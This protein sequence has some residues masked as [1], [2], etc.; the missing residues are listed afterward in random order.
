MSEIMLSDENKLNK[1]NPY[2][3]GLVAWT[4][5]YNYEQGKTVYEEPQLDSIQ[6]MKGFQEMNGLQLSDFHMVRTMSSLEPSREIQPDF[7][8][9]YIDGLLGNVFKPKDSPNDNIPIFRG[10]FPGPA[11]GHWS[12]YMVVA[13]AVIVM[14][15]FLVRKG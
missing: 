13:L 4:K 9:G 7:Q 2:V 8:T 15:W 6:L 12:M 5:P 10:G 11:Q 3:D 14:L 1:I